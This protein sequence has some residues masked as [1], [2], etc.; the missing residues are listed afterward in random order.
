MASRYWVAGG[1]GSWISTTNWAT[2]SGGA[3]GASVPTSADNAIVDAN[4]GTSP[5]INLAGVGSCLDLDFTGSITPTLTGASS[6][7][8][9]GSLTFISALTFSHTGNYNFKSTS[10]GKTIT[11][12][13]KTTAGNVIFDGVGGDWTLQDTLNST[14]S[15][16]LT[17][18]GLDTNGKTINCASFT[19]SNTNVRTL[20]LGA[21]PINLT[22]NWFISVP[23][24]LTFSVGTSSII[25]SGAAP[26]FTGGGLTYNIVTLTGASITIADSNTYGTLTFTAGKTVIITSATTQ[27]Y[28][29]LVA[30]GTPASKVTIRSTSAGSAAIMSRSSGNQVIRNISLKDITATGGATF[31]ALGTTNVSGNTGWSYQMLIKQEKLSGTEMALYHIDSNGAM[32][33]VSG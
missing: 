9:F 1:T 12:A 3:S 31:Y 14:A 13:G 28:T 19:S 27:T 26:T 24:N 22:G 6:F 30:N 17:N 8:I 29:S 11:W 23:T 5:V 20:T 7:N 2:T 15:V 18:G 16:T 25:M 32:Q 21:S 33:K 4:S 10:T